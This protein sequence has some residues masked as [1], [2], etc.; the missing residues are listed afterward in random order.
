MHSRY[1]DTYD[2]RPS[3]SG[4]PYG[5]VNQW[6]YFNGKK[7]EKPV[8]E[9]FVECA[10]F[11]TTTTAI[12]GKKILNRGGTESF[13]F[14]FLS[15]PFPALKLSLYNLSWNSETFPTF[16][17]GQ[18][19]SHNFKTFPTTLQNLSCISKTFPAFLKPFLHKPFLPFKTFPEFPKV[20]VATF[21]FLVGLFY[22]EQFKTS[23]DNT[24][25]QG[26]RPRGRRDRGQIML[27]K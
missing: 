21:G 6:S 13:P 2:S 11:T 7:W 25:M 20:Q 19:L 17:L 8:G 15:S 10:A 24:V 14:P 3:V 27:T 12:T 22:F 4:P 1:L 18:N 26:C 16:S 9:I 5:N 23:A